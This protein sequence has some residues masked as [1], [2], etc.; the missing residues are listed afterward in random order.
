[1]PASIQ[2]KLIGYR[3]STVGF[4]KTMLIYSG[5][6]AALWTIALFCLK[7]RHRPGYRTEKKRWLPQNVDGAF[8]SVALSVFVG[9]FGYLASSLAPFS[10]R[11]SDFK[12]SP[13]YFITTYTKQFVPSLDP[14]SLL[15][16]LPLILMN[17]CAGFGR[18][19]TT[20]RHPCPVVLLEFD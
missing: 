5:I 9:L 10:C 14:K 13:F 18:V 20:H 8:Y 2:D 15:V 3:L 4:R 16:A 12:Q 17:F 6:M 11:L 1:M 7:E 19:S